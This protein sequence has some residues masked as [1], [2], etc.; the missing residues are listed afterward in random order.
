MA[1][2]KIKKGDKVVVLSGKDNV[3][4]LLA[5]KRSIAQLRVT[6]DEFNPQSQPKITWPAALPVRACATA[7][8]MPASSMLTESFSAPAR[9]ASR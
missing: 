2:A 7:A 5:D 6:V 3:R 4:P 1:A 8:A 9:M